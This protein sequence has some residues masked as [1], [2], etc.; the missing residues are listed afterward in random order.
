MQEV[1]RQYGAV[2]ISV[3]SA[4]LF[5]FVVGGYFQYNSGELRNRQIEYF[6]AIAEIQEENDVSVEISDR[7]NRNFS[8]QEKC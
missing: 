1:F 8:F 7:I 3:I 5:I 4:V 6:D 2:V